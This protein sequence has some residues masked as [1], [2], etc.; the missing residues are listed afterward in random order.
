M[1]GITPRS[2]SDVIGPDKRPVNET[3]LWEYL[4][5]IDGYEPSKGK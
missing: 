5:R 1:K 4:I 2:L 3:Y